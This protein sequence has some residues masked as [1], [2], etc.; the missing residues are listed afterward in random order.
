MNQKDYKEI[1][2]LFKEFWKETDRKCNH[3][4]RQVHSEEEEKHFNKGTQY[5]II[6]IRKL[7][8]KLLRCSK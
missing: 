4:L 6:S 7:K 1:E 3:Y 2:E 8:K 5:Y